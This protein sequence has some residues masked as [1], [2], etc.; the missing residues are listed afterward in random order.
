[1]WTENSLL[2][3]ELLVSLLVPIDNSLCGFSIAALYFVQV[4]TRKSCK[5]IKMHIKGNDMRFSKINMDQEPPFTSS[6]PNVYQ[7]VPLVFFKI[8]CRSEVTIC[9]FK[10]KRK[11]EIT[12]CISKSQCKSWSIIRIS[13]TISRRLK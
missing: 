6:R 5:N 1:M 7:K 12:I 11:S 8:K 4:L 13:I 9:I 3:P 10:T 2:I